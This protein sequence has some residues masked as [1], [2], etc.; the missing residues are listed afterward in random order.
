MTED[1]SGIPDA[2]ILGITFDY[3]SPADINW[4]SLTA[5]TNLTVS[6]HFSEYGFNDFFK[7]VQKVTISLSFLGQFFVY[8]VKGF[9]LS[10]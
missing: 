1:L 4:T 10:F 5:F 8:T 9:L 6:Y 7:I 2:P 3:R